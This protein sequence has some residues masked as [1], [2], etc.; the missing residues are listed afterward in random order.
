MDRLA[1][2]PLTRTAADVSSH[3]VSMPR[4]TS[5]TTGPAPQ[6]DGVG[7]GASRDPGGRDDGEPADGAV[8]APPPARDVRDDAQ[9]VAGERLDSLL[10][11]AHGH[12]DARRGEDEAGARSGARLNGDAAEGPLRQRPHLAGDRH[13]LGCDPHDAE[14]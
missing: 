7:D 5:A 11:T 1:S 13:L 6:R 8:R 3:D 4:M 12:R 10:R 9:T 2:S 14:G